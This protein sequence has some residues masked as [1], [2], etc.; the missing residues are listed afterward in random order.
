MYC[1]I[2]KCFKTDRTYRA[3]RYIMFDQIKQMEDYLRPN[4]R[5][6]YVSFTF[7]KQ[8]Y[9]TI[10]PNKGGFMGEEMKFHVKVSMKHPVIY[11]RSSTTSAY[12]CFS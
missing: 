1:P 2:D 8:F 3:R 6:R 9:L 7:K 11:S 10:V 4:N 5:I 12:L